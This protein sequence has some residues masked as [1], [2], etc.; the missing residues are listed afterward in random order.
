MKT[1]GVRAGFLAAWILL[2]SVTCSAE[3]PALLG[4]WPLDGKAGP[5]GTEIP[6]NQTGSAGT[7]RPT[8]AGSIAYETAV[9]GGFVYD[10]VARASQPNTGSL[11]LNPGDSVRIPVELAD[12]E[13]SFTLE[14]FIKPS[15]EWK[16]AALGFQHKD[17]APFFWAGAY[18]LKQHNQTYAG[19]G[20]AMKAERSTWNTGHYLSISRLHKETLGW[21]HLALNYDG[22]TKTATFVFDYYESKSHVLK[23]PLAFK[24][25]DLVLGG[26]DYEGLIDSVRLTRGIL[27]PPQ[28]Q[29]A[30]QT[31]LRGISFASEETLLP[32]GTGYVCVKEHFG[33]V[34]NGV[35]DDTAAFRK[36]FEELGNKVPL[37]FNTLYVPPGTYRITDTIRFNRFFCLQGAGREKT[38]FK[39]DDRASGYADKEKPK[40]FLVGSSSAGLPG[41]YKGVNGSS[42]GLYAYDFTVDTG[43]GNPGAVGFEFHA[44]NTGCARRITIR[45]GDGEGYMALGLMHKCVGPAL[46]EDVEL[47]GFDYGTRMNYQEYSMTFENIRLRRQNIAGIEVL[48]NILAARKI[49]SVNSVPALVGRGENSMLTILDSSLTGGAD[50]ASAIL[51]EGALFCRNVKTEGYG[52]AIHEKWMEGEKE[53][54][55]EKTRSVK[56]LSIAEHVSQDRVLNPRPGGAPAGATGSLNLPIEETPRTDWGQPRDWTSIYA[57]ESKKAGDDWGPAIQ[58]ALDSGAK[59]VYFPQGGYAVKTP[60][61]VRGEVQRLFGMRSA[62]RWHKDA[63]QGTAK[64]PVMRFET[65][66]ASRAVTIERLEISGTLHSGAATL[67]VLDGD[68]APFTNAPGCGKLFLENTVSTQYHFSHPQRVWARQWN[69]EEHG[70]GP[71]ITSKGA[72]IWALGFKTE[73]DSSKLWA[74]DGA[75]TEI[76]GAFIYPIGKIPKDRPIFKNTDSEMSLVYGTSVYQANHGVHII[77]TKKGAAVEIGNDRLKWVGSRGRMDLYNS[78]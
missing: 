56:G 9:P 11:R 26:P 60:F 30:V 2:T 50:G 3:Q 20:V 49:D 47:I 32:R 78:R 1:I 38:I 66:D 6:S 24:G 16:G 7:T 13:A 33:A 39:L 19:A 62:I 29:R 72:T 15:R 41:S 43:S 76:L 57:F 73:Y 12:E 21:R 48:G 4:F 74:S 22:K 18:F 55:T 68:V 64:E 23:E 44:N 63:P 10:A 45:S 51:A 58:A 52:N 17:E 53:N 42:I 46:I 36:A 5:V 28:F 65:A 67:V 54:M 40:P 69:V 31:E 27:S 77:D 35:V 75:K 8:K 34:G 70:A 37:A 25:C 14:A 61:V 59:T 71:C